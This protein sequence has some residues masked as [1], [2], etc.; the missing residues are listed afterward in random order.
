[1]SRNG[2]SGDGGRGAAVSSTSEVVVDSDWHECDNVCG[3]DVRGECVTKRGLSQRRGRESQ[4][5]SSSCGASCGG[6]VTRR[7]RVILE[8]GMG[9]RY[10]VIAHGTGSRYRWF[11]NSP[12]ILNLIDGV[13]WGLHHWS[14]SWR[15]SCSL[16]KYSRSGNRHPVTAGCPLRCCRR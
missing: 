4:P 1:M 7:V 12:Q 13:G 3:G 9:S 5:N 8:T 15:L 11:A 10:L 6:L 2:G 14:R 16:G